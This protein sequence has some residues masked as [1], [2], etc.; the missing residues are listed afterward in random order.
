MNFLKKIL[1][2]HL[3]LCLGFVFQASAKDYKFK[4]PPLSGPVIDEVGALGSR[5]IQTLERFLRLFNQKGVAQFQVYI[6]SSLQGLPVEQAAIEI[7][8]QWKLGDAKKDNGVLFLIVPPE[9]K[10]RIEVGQGLEGVLPDVVVKRIL[11][12]EVAPLF[13]QQ[14]MSRGILLGSLKA[15]EKIDPDFFQNVGPVD[16]YKKQ[17]RND[18]EGTQLPPGFIIVIFIVFIIFRFFLGGGPRSRGGPWG[19]FGGGGFGGGS[20]GGGWSGG[21]GGFSGGGASSDW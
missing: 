13:R 11:A 12:D 8:E 19:G 20:S 17:R 4:V 1:F 6:T 15:L 5:D 18:S 14:Q 10:M 2:I 16:S 7:V 9:K 21:G 3:F